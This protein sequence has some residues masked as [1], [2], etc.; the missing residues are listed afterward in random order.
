MC[1]YVC[2]TYIEGEPSLSAR[3][4]T[5]ETHTYTYTH[6]LFLTDLGGGREEV[7]RELLVLLQALGQRVPA[8]LAHAFCAHTE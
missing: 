1:M 6:T 4:P 3:S 8:V 5:T 2:L 7:G